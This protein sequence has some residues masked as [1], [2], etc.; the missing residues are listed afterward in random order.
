[1]EKFAINIIPKIVMAYSYNNFMYLIIFKFYAV[2]SY[3]IQ[4]LVLK[5]LAGKK[6]W[7]LPSVGIEKSCDLKDSASNFVDKE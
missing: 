3:L 1:M 2:L 6:R 7:H 5:R 4:Q